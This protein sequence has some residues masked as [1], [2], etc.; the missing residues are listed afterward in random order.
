MGQKGKIKS[1]GVLKTATIGAIVTATFMAV[2]IALLLTVFMFAR[3]ARY[4]NGNTVATPNTVVQPSAA[5]TPS[6]AAGPNQKPETKTRH[7]LRP[8]DVPIIVGVAALFYGI[9][10][11]LVFGLWSWLYNLLSPRFGG[12]VIEWTDGPGE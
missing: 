4:L 5:A 11:F 3:G 2:P 9:F 6:T 8:R 12:I 7:P 1:F 10:G